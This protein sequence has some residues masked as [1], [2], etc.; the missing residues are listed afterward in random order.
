MPAN[1]SADVQAV[2]AHVDKTFSGKNVTAI[3]QLKENFGLGNMTHLDDVAGARAWSLF[4]SL[5]PNDF[6]IWFFI[7]SSQ[8]YVG[9]AISSSYLGSW[10]TIFQVLRRTGSSERS[11]STSWRFWTRSR[12]GCLGRL[13]EKLLSQDM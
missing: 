13:L 4:K 6:L 12:V 2:I 9:L 11:T 1:C 5:A 10:H 8:Q 3:Q 7:F